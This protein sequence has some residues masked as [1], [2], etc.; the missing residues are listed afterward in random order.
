MTMRRMM[1]MAGGAMAPI[2]LLAL[3]FNNQWL[4]EAVQDEI[5][6]SSGFGRL[7]VTFQFPNWRLTTEGSWEV[8]FA[9]NFQLLLFLGLLALLV[10][11]AARTVEPGRGPLGALVTGWWA[12]CVAGGVA[13]LIGG[14]L[15][16]W[17]LNAPSGGPFRSQTIWSQIASGTT[18]GFLFGWIAGLGALAGFLFTRPRG[19]AAQQPYGQQPYGG[20]PYAQQPY[21]QQQGAQ[22]PQPGVPQPGMPQQPH[23]SAVPYVP[24]QGQP[25]QQPQQQAQQ[26][27]WGAGVPQQPGAPQQFGAPPVPPQPPAQPGQA[28]AQPPQQPE[29][30]QPEAQQ[31]EPQQSEPGEPRQ[32]PQEPEASEPERGGD[33]EPA[34]AGASED[35]PENDDLKLSDRTV[36]D[37]RRDDD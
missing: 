20:A 4:V 31:P 30:Q 16:V 18:Y 35:T 19:Q 36:V 37:R 33:A 24:P 11:A 32:E 25:Q 9:V 29:P 17:A 5:D 3:L 21:P 14:A 7:V 12:S 1:V 34:G 13:G 23:P 26:P 15:L 22:M 8:W 6:P 2:A 27:Q 10:F 28:P